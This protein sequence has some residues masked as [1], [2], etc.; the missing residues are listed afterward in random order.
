MSLAPAYASVIQSAQKNREGKAFTDKLLSMMRAR[1]HLSLLPEIVRILEREPVKASA[2][3]TVASEA[4]LKAAASQIKTALAS[5]GQEDLKH[6]TVID[7]RVVGG[8]AVQTRS[9]IIDNTYRTALVSIY[10]K[11]TRE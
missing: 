2:T 8:Y 6:A 4:E 5:L 10:Q 3:V 7:P 9:S 1:G 11:A